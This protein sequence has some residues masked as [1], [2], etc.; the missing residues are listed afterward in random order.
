MQPNLGDSVV[1]NTGSKQLVEGA[2]SNVEDLARPQ[3]GEEHP[4]KEDEKAQTQVGLPLE[5]TQLPH[6]PSLTYE[7]LTT[8]P[9][10]AFPGFLELDTEDLLN[11]NS[12][13]VWKQFNSSF[14]TEYFPPGPFN[15]QA[16]ATVEKPFGL[17]DD[18]SFNPTANSDHPALPQVEVKTAMDSIPLPAPP[19]TKVDDKATSI[20]LICHLCPRNPTFSDVSHLLTHVSSKSHLA[21]EFKLKHSKKVEDHDALVQYDQW[22]QKHGV[23]DLVANRIA[24]KEQKKA[25]KRQ[26]A[27][28]HEH[29]KKKPRKDVKNEVDDSIQ[30]QLHQVAP[31]P[32]ANTW[33]LHTPRDNTFDDPYNTPTN[34]RFFN[35]YH[36]SDSP[37]SSTYIK[38]EGSRSGTEGAEATFLPETTDL[39]NDDLS[40]TKLKGTVYPGMS[41]FDAATEEQ[42]RKRNQKKLP[43]VLQNMVL[44]SES[45]EQYE[46]I[47][48]GDMSGITRTRN[49]YDS[50]SIDGSPDGKG[51]MPSTGHK[52]RARR[53]VVT[54]PG[55]RRQTRAST[56]ATSGKVGKRGAVVSKKRALKVEE[57][58]D[59]D[60]G[61]NASLRAPSRCIF[62]GDADEVSIEDDVFQER[63][64]HGQVT[65][66]SP[67]AGHPF[68]HPTAM[69]ALPTNMPLNMSSSVF[70]KNTPNYFDGFGMKE[71]DN[72]SFSLQQPMS[73]P[74]YFA[75]PS[76][77]M[78]QNG[79]NPLCVQR[80]DNFPFLYGTGS[81][82]SSKPSNTAFQSMNGTDYSGMGSTGQFHTG[83]AKRPQYDI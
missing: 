77:N 12:Q 73:M 1:S 26:R 74:S 31:R 58:I 38:Q 29:T 59:S 6:V 33:H 18:L 50:P 28:G 20:P 51:N 2:K 34:K 3:A 72:L 32:S 48:D 60:D 52:R 30:E 41:I 35:V 80:Q 17:N 7:M 22:A 15:L 62:D 23:N 46:C 14:P 49:V 61:T 45:V 5:G 21:S 39:A 47:W 36:F 16:G 9:A 76:H 68:G 8:L 11:F 75:P 4:Q 40:V 27:A 71:N 54:S 55:A 82:D 67:L 43:S 81:F 57:D 63:R 66:T 79:L 56:R 24:A 83:N 19:A 65:T 78:Q 37:Q 44:T 69:Q 25:P 53:V 13:E 64:Q 42:R 10:A 70:N